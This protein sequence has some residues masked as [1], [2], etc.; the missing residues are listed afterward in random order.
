M[1]LP[2]GFGDPATKK[3]KEKCEVLRHWRSQK[4]GAAAGA[5]AHVRM[6]LTKRKKS[7]LRF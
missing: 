3:K 4:G 2:R 6:S 1:K 5:L 7:Y